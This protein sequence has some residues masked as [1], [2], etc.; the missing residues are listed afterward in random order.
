[1]NNFDIFVDSGAN[2]PDNLVKERGFHV[3]PFYYRKGDVERLCYDES[4]PF[5]KIAKEFYTEMRAG[6]EF[7]TSLINAQRFYEAIV[8]SLQAGRDVL[9]ITMASGISST[10]RQALEAKKMLEEE[11][12]ERK[13]FVI[14]SA[15]ASLGEGLLAL[16]AADLRDAGESVEAVAERIEH[17]VYHLNS[18]LTVEDL[19]YLRRSGRIS[20]ARAIAGT[21]LNIKPVLRADG[22]NPAHIV[23]YETQ[24]GRRK[25]LSALAQSLRERA[26]EPEK[27]TVAIAHCD[28]DEDAN[29]LASLVRE[30]GVKDIIIEYYDLCSGSHV[31]PGT[32]ALFFY[33]KDRRE[34]EVAEEKRLFRKKS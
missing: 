29:Y 34:A 7:Q 24:R 8:P 6:A 12:P 25:A 32:I 13:V 9:L 15:N 31:G 2:I 33:G 21:L 22:D 23:F 26:F 18:Y 5:S 27:Q 4:V 16:R 20:M 14:D 19:K 1:M 28:C 3:I 17:D 10:H 11:F 30:I